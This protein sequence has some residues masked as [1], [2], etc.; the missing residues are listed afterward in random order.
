MTLFKSCFI[1]VVC[2]L[3]AFDPQLIDAFANGTSEGWCREL[4][5]PFEQ[6]LD[7]LDLCCHHVIRSVV[8]SMRMEY[9]KQ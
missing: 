6:G 1:P 2:L 5:H 4:T 7:L 9:Y 3:F 8:T